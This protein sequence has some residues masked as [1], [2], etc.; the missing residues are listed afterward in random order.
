MFGEEG[1]TSAADSVF[2]LGKNPP[3]CAHVPATRSRAAARAKLSIGQSES[4][5]LS[6][7]TAPGTGGVEGGRGGED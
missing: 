7:A 6:W 3:R 2:E 1:K 5:S 4:D